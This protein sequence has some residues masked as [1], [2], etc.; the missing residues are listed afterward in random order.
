[1]LVRRDNRIRWIASAVVL[2]AALLFTRDPTALPVA[3]SPAPSAGAPVYLLL[4]GSLTLAVASVAGLRRAWHGVLGTL[5]E[6][7]PA[8]SLAWL[9]LFAATLVQAVVAASGHSVAASPA[10]SL[11]LPAAVVLGLYLGAGC[12]QHLGV[13]EG[14]FTLPVLLAFAA[15]AVFLQVDQ[16]DSRYLLWLQGSAVLLPPL[17][18]ALLPA[19]WPMATGWLAASAF[20]GLAQLA[21]LLE[22]CTQIP[23]PPGSSAGI[24][25][26][27]TSA[28]V[29][30]LLAGLPRRSLS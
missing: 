12:S 14:V 10:W 30:A 2:L 6:L 18:C 19:P 9:L 8:A 26:L 3:A 23:I 13:R 7:P 4:L 27:L 1:M 17:M 21:L 22:P 16:G 5:S 25:L 28:A 11:S 20:L 24:G 15:L 29:L